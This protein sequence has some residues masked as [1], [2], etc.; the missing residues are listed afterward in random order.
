[1]SE[2]SD[3]ELDD[4]L[5]NVPVPSGIE[6]SVAPAVLFDTAAIDRLL[7]RV[8]VPAGLADRVR[9]GVLA[10]GSGPLSASGPMPRSASRAPAGG[11]AGH[12][13]WSSGLRR[14]WLAAG[15][16]LAAD[17]ATV[18][19]A[20]AIVASMFFAGMELSRRLEAPG[21]AAFADRVTP[22]ASRNVADPD[23]GLARATGADPADIGGR[24][25]ASTPAAGR[26]DDA[27]AARGS[28]VR[29]HRGADVTG[30]PPPAAEPEAVAA[31]GRSAMGVEVRAAPSGPGSTERPR[32]ATG[33]IRVVSFPRAG[34]AVPRLPGFDIAFEM[35]HGEPPFVDPAAHP[36]LAVDRPPLA[37]R[38]DSFDAVC[39]TALAEGRERPRTARRRSQ[40]GG[41]PA[42]RVEEIFAA[43]PAP[44]R[45]AAAGTGPAL[46]VEAVRSLRAAEETFL[47]EVCAAAAPLS[48]G[49]EQSEPL[50]VLLVLDQSAGSSAPLAWRWVCR[51]LERVIDQL[52]PA[53]R[54]S[55]I[56][57]N[58][59][60]RV[61]AVRAG[62]ERLRMVL[63]ELEREPAAREADFDAAFRLVAAVGRRE[64]VSKRV[65]VLAHADAIERSR[66][67]G[68]E[69]LVAW[70]AATAAASDRRSTEFVLLDPQEPAAAG[71]RIAV[72]PVAIGRALLGRVFDRSTLAA[73]AC[74]LE[75]AFDPRRVAA[76][77][78]V[79]YRQ[80]AADAVA[81]VEPASIDLHAGE[82]VRVVYEVKLHGTGEAAGGGG[83]VSATLRWIPPVAAG[84]Q[85]VVAVLPHT[86]LTA[87]TRRP[88]AAETALPAPH[89]CELLLAMGLGD[90]AGGSAHAGPPRQT[91][92][93]VAALAT[94]W[95][96][97]GDVTPTGALLLDCLEQR[98]LLREPLQP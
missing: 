53:D 22:P 35:A 26:A 59:R 87:V 68:R 32:G 23:R 24:R 42:V 63:A 78:I 15:I 62:S 96:V 48:R 52:R 5:R 25:T 72:D 43:L 79:G 31:A 85:R 69:A 47:V 9:R 16:D 54:L 82:V 2:P 75:V 8:D 67:E 56:V 33:G 64:G 17:L 18:T 91:A 27:V 71:G 95:R 7:C 49:V 38:T 36:G 60:P 92:A 70:Q 41:M 81:N 86:A 73:A 74:R 21:Q 34:R 4:R 61:V 51:G 50:D 14:R 84:E 3:R 6:G 57:C 89:D 12:G 97:R 40:Q 37:L 45:S 90:L 29:P 39:M 88:G 55:V 20:L 98:G 80:T 93:A 30:G 13:G 10:A 1:M 46:T 11:A 28:P 77:R 19:A 76:Y 58:D 66:N 94:R 83:P 65:V 44:A